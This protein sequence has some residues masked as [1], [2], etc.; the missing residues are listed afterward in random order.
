MSDYRSEVSIK[1]TSDECSFVVAPAADQAIVLG[2]GGDV[3]RIPLG[4]V[5][6]V[7]RALIRVAEEMKE[8][9]SYPFGG[10]PGS[11]WGSDNG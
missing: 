1:V 6:M 7:A 8:D 10:A 9:G 11:R 5:A 3:I 2:G 4:A